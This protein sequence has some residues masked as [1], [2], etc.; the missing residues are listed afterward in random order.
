[1]GCP[2]ERR[3]GQVA[4]CALPSSR[5]VSEAGRA[6]R[7]IQARAGLA[8]GAVA[9]ALLPVL[10][11]LSVMRR[12]V[13]GVPIVVGVQVRGQLM[14]LLRYDYSSVSATLAAAAAAAAGAL[15]TAVTSRDG[16]V[17]WS[18][19]ASRKSLS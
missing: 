12:I 1:M 13:V 7:R 8:A 14:P 9:I 18:T 6:S 10:Q 11:S 16:S 3:R 17:S 2:F 5:A 19:G 4:G 15:V